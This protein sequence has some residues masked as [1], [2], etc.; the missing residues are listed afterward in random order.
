MTD[1]S[2]WLRRFHPVAGTD[3]V[4]VFFPHAGGSASF[5]HPHTVD[6]APYVDT[7]TIQYPGRQERYRESLVAD[8]GELAEL[9]YAEVAPAGSEQRLVFFGHSMGAALAFEVALRMEE[10]LGRGPE[11]LFLSGRRAPSSERRPE[12]VHLMGDDGLIAEMLNNGVT[13]RRLLTDP[14]TLRMI[15]PV[16]RNDY[17]AIETYRPDPAARV[18]CPVTALVGEGDPKC[19]VEEAAAWAEHTSGDFD[20]E[21]FAEG[22]H[23]FLVPHRQDVTGV[24]RER[25]ARVP[26]EMR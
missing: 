3:Q 20:L 13:D 8:I 6:L 15:L 4:V 24:V 2:P 1:E 17:R 25:L 11:R 19:T 22:A 5:F 23:F 7:L 9:I 26:A 21:V 16:V 10:R 12:T 14:D 18:A